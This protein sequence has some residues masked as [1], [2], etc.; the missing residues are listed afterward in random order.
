MSSTQAIWGEKKTIRNSIQ[1]EAG[2]EAFCHLAV[3]KKSGT[4]HNSGLFPHPP[5]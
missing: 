2:E 1:G 3:K 4:L 5:D